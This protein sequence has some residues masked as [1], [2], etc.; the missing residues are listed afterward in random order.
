MR[1][2]IQIA[3]LS[4]IEVIEEFQLLYKIKLDKESK[5][6]IDILKKEKVWYKRNRKL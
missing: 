6:F 2:V 5:G 3:N 4:N 1:V